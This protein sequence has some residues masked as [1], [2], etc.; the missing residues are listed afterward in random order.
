M[1]DPY[2]DLKMD[3]SVK[4]KQAVVKQVRVAGYSRNVFDECL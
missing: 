2:T 1:M 3:A 4:A